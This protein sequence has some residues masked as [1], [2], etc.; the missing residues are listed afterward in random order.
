MERFYGPD[1]LVELCYISS[2]ANYRHFNYEPLWRGAG[3]SMRVQILAL[4]EMVE[5]KRV[6]CLSITHKLSS[7][8]EAELWVIESRCWPRLHGVA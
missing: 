7:Q 5:R 3:I 8:D 2:W 1:L 6:V 4:P